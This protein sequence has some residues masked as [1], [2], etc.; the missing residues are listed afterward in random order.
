MAPPMV[1]ENIVTDVA[2][3]SW[4]LGTVCWTAIK[5]GAIIKPIPAPPHRHGHHHLRSRTRNPQ[6]C[7][8][9]KPYAQSHAPGED[10]GADLLVEEK[11]SADD[12]T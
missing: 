2:T 11:A 5:S 12:R 7:K 1:R 9:E 3:P 6:P 4:L 10:D 8:E